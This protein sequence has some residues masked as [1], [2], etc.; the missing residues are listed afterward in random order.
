MLHEKMDNINMTF[1]HCPVQGTHANLSTVKT[2]THIH[3]KIYENHSTMLNAIFKHF[4]K[5]YCMKHY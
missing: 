3:N 4:S 1:L 2:N 5:K